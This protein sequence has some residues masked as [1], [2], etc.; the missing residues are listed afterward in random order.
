MSPRKTTAAA[1]QK[2]KSH[3]NKKITQ[4]IANED[5]NKKLVPNSKWVQPKHGNSTRNTDLVGRGFSSITPDDSDSNGDSDHGEQDDSDEDK[6]NEAEEPDEIAPSDTKRKKRG[7]QTGISISLSN[8]KIDG[9]VITR[10]RA[11]SN[12]VHEEEEID[13]R[14]KASKPQ[15]DGDALTSD[16]DDDYDGVDLISES[17]DDKDMEKEEEKLIIQSEEENDYLDRGT[18]PQNGEPESWEDFPDAGIPSV[19]ENTFFSEHFSRTDPYSSSALYPPGSDVQGYS[20][21]AVVPTVTRRVRFVDEVE[22]N[23]SSN[24]S[25]SDDDN[26]VFPDLFLQ[27]DK[28]DASFRKMLEQDGASSDGEGS[29]WDL[30]FHDDQEL[31]FGEVYGLDEEDSDMDGSSSGYESM[32]LKRD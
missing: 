1:Q 10:K 17:D 30:G 29:Y 24:S 18:N 21:P 3:Q 9:G 6:E 11:W 16:D 12:R 13:R 19:E 27:Q 25:G 31:D 8:T 4:S 22:G 5:L 20:S 2:A 15:T 28:L 32:L 7:H 26:D 23:N 14:T